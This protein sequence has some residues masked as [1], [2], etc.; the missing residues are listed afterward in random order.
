[1]YVVVISCE[2]GSK[3]EAMNNMPPSSQGSQ[4]NSEQDFGVRC[5]CGCNEVVYDSPKRLNSYNLNDSEAKKPNAC[6]N[7]HVI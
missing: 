2:I 6:C 3:E 7:C 4:I 1:M 5:P